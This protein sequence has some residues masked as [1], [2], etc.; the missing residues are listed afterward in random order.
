V[1]SAKSPLAPDG[2]RIDPKSLGSGS[3]G[4]GRKDGVSSRPRMQAVL[5]TGGSGKFRPNSILSIEEQ[6]VLFPSGDSDITID[7]EGRQ[8]EDVKEGVCS[9]EPPTMAAVRVNDSSNEIERERGREQT[10]SSCID[11][12]SAMGL[13]INSGLCTLL[14]LESCVSASSDALFLKI[15]A[16]AS[17]SSTPTFGS[18]TFLGK[19]LSD[20]ETPRTGEV[21]EIGEGKGVREKARK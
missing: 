7:L 14:G 19:C 9:S 12:P 4:R 11:V 3:G 13:G 1:R 20:L 6:P 16:T 21:D 10:S 15:V 5:L 17:T 18:S 2:K 8:V